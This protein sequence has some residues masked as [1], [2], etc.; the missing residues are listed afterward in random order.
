[1]RALLETLAATTPLVLV[2]DDVHWA[3]SASAELLGALLHRLPSASVLIAT[4]GR[5]SQLPEQL[6][7]SFERAHRT[8]TLTRAELG[9][10]SRANT[11]ELLAGAVAD[12][13]VTTLFD[14]SGGNPFYLEQLARAL[15]REAG[16]ARSGR[17]ERLADIGIPAGVAAALTTELAQL[18]PEVRRVLEGA[19]V[20]GDPFEPEL[21]AAAASA[22]D[23][24]TLDGARRTPAA[25]PRWRHHVPRRFRFRHPLVRR[26][27]YASA[28]AAW[29]LGAHERA[30][31]AL[32][33][34]GASATS[35]AH[36]V[37][38]S[39]RAGDAAVAVLFEAGEAAAR[40]A[41]ES[42]ARWFA[43]RSPG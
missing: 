36:H 1:M 16:P 37:E 30:A 10:L 40:S 19:A 35:R 13:E 21:A 31:D 24:V 29:R 7:A 14:E 42:A 15:T 22:A 32:A 4:A 12:A 2:L 38:Q 33:A 28:P 6:A 18:T 27:V 39:A 3:D 25:R 23:E 9:A 11:Q 20:V 5:Q 17:A 41:P 26:A 43:E 34:R 8:G